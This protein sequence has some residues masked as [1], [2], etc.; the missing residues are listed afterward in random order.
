MSQTTTVV[1]LSCYLQAQCQDNVFRIVMPSITNF[2]FEIISTILKKWGNFTV[3]CIFQY[4]PGSYT[5]CQ[6][7]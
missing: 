3:S 6:N 2:P 5:A 7:V 4:S 1:Q